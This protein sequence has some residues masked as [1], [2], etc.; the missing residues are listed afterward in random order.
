MSDNGYLSPEGILEECESY[1]HTDKAKEI[2]ESLGQCHFTG[3][4]AE[5]YL[6]DRGYVVVRTRDVYAKL[7][8]VHG[9]SFQHLT[10]KQRKWLEDNYNSFMREKQKAVD[11]LMDFYDKE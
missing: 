1:G 4:R 5:E 11:E 6:L 10:D 8:Y 7:G 9:D 3:I 2:C